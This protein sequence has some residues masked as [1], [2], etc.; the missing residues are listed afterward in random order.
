MPSRH[1][2]P[3][4]WYLGP[5][6]LADQ[7]EIVNKR[8]GDGDMFS[9][10]AFRQQVMLKNLAMMILKLLYAVKIDCSSN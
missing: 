5:P 9:A 4:R 10:C 7:S 1:I 8:A 6:D 3:Q 2:A